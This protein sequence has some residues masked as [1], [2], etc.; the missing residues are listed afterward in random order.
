MRP[1]LHGIGKASGTSDFGNGRILSFANVDPLWGVSSQAPDYLNKS[2]AFKAAPP[3]E[4][5]KRNI[6]MD[7]AKP[8]MAS[9]WSRSTLP[10]IRPAAK[11]PYYS[12]EV[13][14]DPDP[15]NALAS[16]EA[17]RKHG[18]LSENILQQ[19]NNFVTAR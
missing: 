14:S 7:V 17:V 11:L 4:F 13:G 2:G 3:G 16:W 5:G 6:Y 15:Y 12:K 18:N 1:K 10:R 19:S 9:L 8:K